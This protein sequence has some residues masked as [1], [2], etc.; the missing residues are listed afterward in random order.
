PLDSAASTFGATVMV[1]SFNGGY[2]GYVTP[3]KYYDLDHHETRLMNWYPPGTGEYVST[4]L[5]K[6]IGVVMAK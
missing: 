2:I 5:Q 1:T 6:L 3:G 4:C